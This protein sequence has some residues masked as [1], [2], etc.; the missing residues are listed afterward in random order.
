MPSGASH[1]A[2]MLASVTDIPKDE[3]FLVESC[4]NEELSPSGRG[5]KEPTVQ[6]SDLILILTGKKWR[7]T[8]VR[9]DIV[10]NFRKHE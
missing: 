8:R 3:S 9:M 1:G 4:C 7:C 5:Y 10:M 2:D 6:E